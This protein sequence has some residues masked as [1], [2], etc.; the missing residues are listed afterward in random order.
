M[1][2]GKVIHKTLTYIQNGVPERPEHHQQ[3]I[4]KPIAKIDM[5]K[6]FCAG[7]QVRAALAKEHSQINKI[8][9]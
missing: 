1:Q 8:L 4:P 6:W 7:H 2:F 9:C 3:N 5:E